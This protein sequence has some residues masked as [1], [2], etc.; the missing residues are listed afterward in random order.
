MTSLACEKWPSAPDA[1]GPVVVAAVW[2]L[3]VAI[4]VVAVVGNPGSDIA[5]QEDV[6]DGQGGRD[7]RVVR[8]AETEASEIHELHADHSLVGH[9]E[10]AVRLVL[11]QHAE[12]PDADVVAV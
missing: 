4:E 5:S 9:G 8:C 1:V 12:R 3:A 7:P 11:D 2:L 10:V 6:D